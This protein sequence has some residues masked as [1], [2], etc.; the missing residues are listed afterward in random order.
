MKT[1]RKKSYITQRKSSQV[2]EKLSTQAPETYHPNYL[3][4][5]GD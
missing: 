4:K 2:S 3:S 1:I 5:E